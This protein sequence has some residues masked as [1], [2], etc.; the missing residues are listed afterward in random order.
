MTTSVPCPRPCPS[1]SSSTFRLYYMPSMIG[2]AEPVRLLFCELDVSWEEPW[3]SSPFLQSPEACIGEL[4][5]MRQQLSQPVFGLPILEHR[6]HECVTAERKEGES[7]AAS[8]D[9]FFLGQTPVISHYL[10][11]ILCEGRLL[12]RGGLREG[13]LACQLAEDVEDATA[14]AYD[15]WSNFV[16]K[17][18]E[19][20]SDTAIKEAQGIKKFWV[21]KR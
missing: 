20:V 10:A 12:P 1:A 15:S 7:Q 17:A 18:R 6:A 3:S 8:G 21:E 19:F 2:R 16:S 5:R 14:E 4:E 13:H 9:A 11:S